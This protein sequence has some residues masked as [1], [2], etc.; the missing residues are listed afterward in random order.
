MVSWGIKKGI[1]LLFSGFT[2]GYT[3]EKFNEIKETTKD[4]NTSDKKT[5]NRIMS[6]G[7]FEL[8][9]DESEKETKDSDIKW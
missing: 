8:P 7:T 4:W 3:V 1:S 9:T 2:T 5:V 6:T